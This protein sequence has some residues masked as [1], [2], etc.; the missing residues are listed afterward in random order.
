M[1]PEIQ[2]NN[3]IQPEIEL[4]TQK[5]EIIKMAPLIEPKIDANLQNTVDELKTSI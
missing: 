5:Y 2:L 1:K 3:E 4:K